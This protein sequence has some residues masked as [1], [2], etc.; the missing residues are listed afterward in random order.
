MKK[1]TFILAGLSLAAAHVAAQEA[2][3]S[4]FEKYVLADPDLEQ[5]DIT[6]V[7][8]NEEVRE[9]YFEQV[10]TH[11]SW[12][13]S[14]KTEEQEITSFDGLKLNAV[15]IRCN[16]DH[17][18]LLMAHGFRTDRYLLLKQ[19]YEM[20][21]RGY[22]TLLIDQRGYGHSQ[23][24]YT[25]FGLKESLDIA[26]WV[27]HLIS[28]DPEAEI[29]LYGVSMGASSILMALGTTLPEN[30]RFVI[31]DSAYSTLPA[32]MEYLYN[33]QMPT[34]FPLYSLY[35]NGIL[36][37][38]LGFKIEDV[39]CLRAVSQNQIPVLFIHSNTD[40]TIPYEQAIDLFNANEGYKKFYPLKNCEH[41]FGCYQDPHYF[42]NI[43][44]F[45]KNI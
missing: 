5:T 2:V 44:Q 24:E 33:K 1:K 23:G 43:E 8:P 20:S 38:K 41:I 16:E 42:D 12:F 10:D 14:V 13:R 25:T 30:V 31:S 40:K 45:I 35:L 32:E 9:L 36:K 6:E 11:V 17:R 4:S 39:D 21:K 7:L 19:A 34:G 37:D 18:Y 27:N 15:L 3:K 22:N 26:Q 28:L 29:G